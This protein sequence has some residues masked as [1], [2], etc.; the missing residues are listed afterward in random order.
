MR[1]ARLTKRLYA[2]LDGKG[3]ALTGGRWN[4]PGKAVT[5]AASCSALAIVEY[6]AH[7]GRCQQVLC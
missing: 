5:Y 7:V 6:L 1:V 4:T 2:N 3:A